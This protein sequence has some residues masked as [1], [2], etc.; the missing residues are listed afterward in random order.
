MAMLTR[1]L[2]IAAFCAGS[3]YLTSAAFVP[4]MGT[5]RWDIV[6]GG[7]AV[8]GLILGAVAAARKWGRRGGA[9]PDP[10]E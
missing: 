5:A 4:S 7:F 2:L 6:F 3:V 10:K 9:R 1:I 8:A